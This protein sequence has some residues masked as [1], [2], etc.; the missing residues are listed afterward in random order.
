M[1][2]EVLCICSTCMGTVFDADEVACLQCDCSFESRNV[3]LIK[4]T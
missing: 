3:I 2:S 1:A 4:V